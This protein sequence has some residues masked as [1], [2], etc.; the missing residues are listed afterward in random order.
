MLCT[1]LGRENILHN[2]GDDNALGE[3]LVEHIEDYGAV[4]ELW[5]YP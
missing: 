3:V 2:E 5:S 4:G 1:L